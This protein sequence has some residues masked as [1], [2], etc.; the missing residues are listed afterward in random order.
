MCGRSAQM[1]RMPC[2]DGAK[3][4]HEVNIG[5]YSVLSI[6]VNRIHKHIKGSKKGFFAREEEMK[7]WC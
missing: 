3:D 5:A 6:L 2:T 1:V 4:P 7:R